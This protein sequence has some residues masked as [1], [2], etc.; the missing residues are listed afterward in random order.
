MSSALERASGVPQLL[1]A[2]YDSDP[3]R[4]RL[5]WYDDAPGD[6]RGE[7]IEL[8]AR[9]LAN[10]VAKAA[11]LLVDELG[12]EP[13]DRLVVDLPVHWRAAYWLLAGWSAGAE[14][15]VV[16]DGE[17]PEVDARAWVTGD[18]LAATGAAETVV[19][20]TLPA[21]ARSWP[22]PGLPAGVLDEAAAVT[23]QPDVF[24]PHDQPEPGAPALRVGGT[25]LDYAGLLPAAR[26]AAGA[27]GWPA[28]VRLLTSA[29]THEPVAG[30]LAPLLL[31]GSVVLVRDPDPE[32]LPQRREDERV[33]AG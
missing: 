23:G 4:P 27:A 20:V 12:V 33:T 3:G 14:V 1:R 11:N 24:E 15:V 8:S 30:L 31:D 10:W 22:G 13:G 21:L 17:R 19:A 29:A 5:T 2:L 7:R 16:R 26:E 6:T 9:V 18:P 25:T 28:D 32:L